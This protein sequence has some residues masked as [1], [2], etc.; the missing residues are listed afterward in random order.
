MCFLLPEN[1]GNINLFLENSDSTNLEIVKCD[2]GFMYLVLDNSLS[3][4][5]G[6]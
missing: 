1:E 6:D 5:Q 3:V 4:H 2:T